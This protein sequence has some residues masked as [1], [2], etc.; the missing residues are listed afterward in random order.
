MI[1]FNRPYITGQEIKYIEDAIKRL[2]LSGDGYYTKA[3]SKF[4]YNRIGKHNFLTNSGTDSLEMA[5]ILAEI[6]PGD[7]VIMPSFTFVSTANAFILRGAVIKFV[8]SQINS[9]N[10]DENQIEELITDK[11][12]AIVIVHYGGIS[13]DMDKIMK[14]S[15][16][17][18]IYI[19]ED[20]AHSI[21]S[22]YKDKP[23]GTIGHFGAFSFHSTKNIISGEGGMLVINDE[24]KI[25]RAEII[26]EKG[27]NRTSFFRGETD[28]YGW[29]DLGSSFLPSEITAAFLLA[30]LESID[31]IQQKRLKIWNEYNNRL[32]FL[33][34]Y[35]YKLPFIP[36]YATNNAHLFYLIC[37]SLSE[38]TE[39]IDFLLKEGIK[40]VFHYQSLHNSNFYKKLNKFSSSL[41]L[42]NS[43]RY[44][45]LLLRLPLFPDLKDD[46]VK[47]IC[48]KITEF[49]NNR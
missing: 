43:E 3:C 8:D 2:E 20:A 27:T 23:L 7:E 33:L 17:H 21:D 10:M 4:I 1:K 5:A 19:I 37:P 28:K 6:S 16:K 22:F 40:A 30:Q 31:I 13:C 11:T 39:L 36:S 18:N 47:Y 45:D 34:D 46:E 41:S 35:G 42:V 49:I 26:R 32:Q 24:K 38:R 25:N 14:L 44:S 48:D 12:K 29:V 15:I 9:P